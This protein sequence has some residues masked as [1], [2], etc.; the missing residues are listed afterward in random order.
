MKYFIIE[1]NKQAGPYTIYELKDK[2]LKSETLVWTEGMTD[3]KPAWQ[4][5]ELRNFLQTTASDATPPPIP[6]TE[7]QQP[8][9]EQPQSELPK[10]KN[11]HCGLIFGAVIVALLLLLAFTN[12]SK[13]RHIDQMQNSLTEAI[14]RETGGDDIFSQGFGMLTKMFA[15]QISG[16]VLN[17]ALH[18]HNYLIFSTTT[19]RWDGKNHTASCGLL[20]HVF[21][22]DEDDVI[23]AIEK[24]DTETPEVDGNADSD[25]EDD[26]YVQA[27]P[28]QNDSLMA[29]SDKSGSV[30][31]QIIDGLG[32]VVKDKVRQETDSSTAS[33]LG[34]IID[35]VA[36]LLKGE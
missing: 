28:Q 20:G 11:G 35:G 16:P 4:V 25:S 33:G 32:N 21:T 22:F 29:N 36:S 17:T 3:W 24:G 9:A 30:N 1:N 19:V 8:A 18:Y 15:R 2:G 12:P 34:K 23:N 13:E 14:E 31:R 5:E 10:K 7:S 26:S 6:P 27:N